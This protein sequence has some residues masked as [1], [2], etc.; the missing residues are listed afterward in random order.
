MQTLLEDDKKM[1]N[2][3]YI[4]QIENHK[5]EKNDIN[6]NTAVI[7]SINESLE[8]RNAAIDCFSVR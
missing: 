4:E 1:F 7:E 6:Q 3:Q 8:M 2:S 5:I